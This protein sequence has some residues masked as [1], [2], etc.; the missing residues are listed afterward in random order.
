[1]TQPPAG[2][3]KPSWLGRVVRNLVEFFGV[4]LLLL[5]AG[6]YLY[7]E[8]WLAWRGQP[9]WAFCRA[10]GLLSLGSIEGIGLLLIIGAI[11][12][13]ILGERRWAI[14]L[15][16]VGALVATPALWMPEFVTDR[17]PWIM[18]GSGPGE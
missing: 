6:G 8:T 10:L 18:T 7:D 12:A 1:M 3:S 16:I 11:V 13:M 9:P 2:H 14:G 4:I 15:V 17:C 5:V